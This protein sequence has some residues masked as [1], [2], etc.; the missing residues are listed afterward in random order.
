MN[1]QQENFFL[2]DF[3]KA[4]CIE[5]SEKINSLFQIP[6]SIYELAQAFSLP[7]DKEWGHWALPCFFLSKKLKKNP[8]EI[9]QQIS[10]TFDNSSVFEKVINKGP[11]LNFFF[12]KSFLKTNLLD[13]LNTGDTF[14]VSPKKTGS[15]LI[16]YSQPNTHKEL[17]IGHTRNLCFGLSLVTL[18][19]K[20]GFPVITCTY[21]GDMGTHVAKCLWYL[22]F[23]NKEPFPLHRKG[24]WLGVIYTKAYKKFEQTEG[25]LEKEKNK[26]QVTHILQQLQK[27]Q[28]EFYDLWQETRLWSQDLMNEVY[29]WAGTEFDHWYWESEMDASSIKWVK[30]LLEQGKL[31]LS[32]SAVGMDL[33]ETLG[34]CLLLKSD[35]NGLYATKDLYLAKKKFEDHKPAKN[36]YVVDQRQEAHFQQVFKVLENIGLPEL[37]KKSSHLKY[38]FVELKTGA[39]SSRAGNIIPIMNLIDTMTDYIKDHFLNKYQGE[40]SDEKIKH[41]AYILAQGAIKYGMNEQDLN[42]KIVFDM[43]EWLKLDGRSGPYIQ[44][45]HARACSLLKKLNSST[46]DKGIKINM[47][48][49][50]SPEEWDLILHLSWF[51]LTM[52]K[53]AWQMKTSPICHYLFELAQKFSRFYQNC[54]IGSLHN[55][56][57][58]HFRLF[59][60]QVV[61]RTLEEGLS[62][63]SIPAPEQM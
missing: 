55:K 41:T 60:V 23:H 49:L 51:S 15:Y 40:W 19:K 3:T 34:F 35:G 61:R 22:A 13:R 39:M 7:P 58:K 46:E 45:A 42:K 10:T 43:K 63:L 53:C 5:L 4:V 16:E 2:D 44:Y 8:A 30:K 48:S 57:Q 32:E 25:S 37:A 28:G 59:L 12:Q 6:V 27:K 33:G 31:Q 14:R 29:Q 1:I 62:I 50:S 9:A 20:R 52:E 47:Q 24:Q 17:H 38:N 18:L 11:Y 21:P 54:P 56:E 36:I 26:K